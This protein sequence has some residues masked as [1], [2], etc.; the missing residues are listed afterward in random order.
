MDIVN[1]VQGVEATIGYQFIESLILWEALQATGNGISSVGT[2]SF[3]DGNMRLALVGDAI[4]KVALLEE[5]YASTESRG[6]YIALLTID[7]KTNEAQKLAATSCKR[8]R[9]MP[10]L[11]GSPESMA[12]T[13]SCLATE[14]RAIRFLLES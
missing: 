2:R 12:L 5:W 9:S 7:L 11:T 13:N 14:R 1:A 3:A 6:L 4:L 10:I 8:S